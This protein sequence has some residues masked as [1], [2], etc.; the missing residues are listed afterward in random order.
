[1][2]NEI[3]IGW[4][5]KVRSVTF[6]SKVIESDFYMGRSENRSLEIDDAA[7][8]SVYFSFPPLLSPF[9]D[10]SL[11]FF[12]RP[13]D[14]GVWTLATNLRHLTHNWSTFGTEN[15]SFLFHFVWWSVAMPI[16]TFTAQ[17]LVGYGLRWFRVKSP[18]TRNTRDGALFPS[19][20]IFQDIFTLF[21]FKIMWIFNY[22]DEFRPLCRQRGARIFFNVFFLIKY[23][24]VL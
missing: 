5:M 10:V 21:L 18:A 20:H 6:R 9:L 4:W 24:W 3:G 22:A 19:I 2:K 7:F 8:S 13:T 23:W 16:C 12:T 1:M 15:F 17:S 14:R 11:V